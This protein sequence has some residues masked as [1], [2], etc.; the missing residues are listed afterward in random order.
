VDFM[1]PVFPD[2][3]C[4]ASSPETGSAIDNPALNAAVSGCKTPQ[5][6]ISAD[7]QRLM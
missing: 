3:A 1:L 5:Y 7:S 4:S 2:A 6:S